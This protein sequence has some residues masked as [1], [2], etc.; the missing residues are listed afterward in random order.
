MA[1]GTPFPRRRSF[2]SSSRAVVSAA[3]RSRSGRLPGRLLAIGSPSAGEPPHAP[4]FGPMR[5][6]KGDAVRPKEADT[7]DRPVRTLFPAVAAQT[8]RA[9][10]CSA[11]EVMG[12]LD[13][14]LEY[15][16]RPRTAHLA[17]CDVDGDSG[18]PVEVDFAAARP[19]SAVLRW[20]CAAGLYNA[21]GQAR[22][23]ECQDE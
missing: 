22:Q 1:R 19:S 8:P 5:S 6:L 16:S 18:C 17:D 12:A 3:Q 2:R 14:V 15:D 20:A 23:Y 9:I 13:P 10:N 11:L 7:D 21:R 4:L